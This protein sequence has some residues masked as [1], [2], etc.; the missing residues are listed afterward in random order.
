MVE[1]G[2]WENP[3]LTNGPEKAALI[4]V[5]RPIKNWG[6]GTWRVASKLADTVAFVATV[7]DMRWNEL[8]GANQE[9]K[10]RAGEGAIAHT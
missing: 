1:R 5:L 7:G 9:C 3:R 2:S 4:V 8:P 6:Q 10:G